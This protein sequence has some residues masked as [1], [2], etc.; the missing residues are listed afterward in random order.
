MAQRE[1]EKEMKK[2]F[3]EYVGIDNKKRKREIL[4]DENGERYFINLAGE[5]QTKCSSCGCWKPAQ[6]KTCFECYVKGPLLK[7]KP[8]LNGTNG[9]QG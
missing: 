2:L 4:V 8:G 7:D 1:K 3:E 6:F 9:K 5:K